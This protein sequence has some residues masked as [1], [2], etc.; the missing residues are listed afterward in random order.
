MRELLQQALAALKTCDWDYDYEEESY[1]TFDEDAVNAAIEALEHELNKPDFLTTDHLSPY[2]QGFVDGMAKQAQ[3]SV[4]RAV[5]AMVTPTLVKL[6]G[7]EM[8]AVSK[9]WV[10]I[11]DEEQSQLYN[12]MY[13]K[14]DSDNVGIIDFMA[15]GWVIEAKLREKN[16]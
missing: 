5:N 8:T 1:K 7:N 9:L 10:G 2:E 11:T 14:F 4:D 16:G 15:I 12:D 6:R 3:S 13:T